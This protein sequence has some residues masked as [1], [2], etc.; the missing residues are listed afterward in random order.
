MVPNEGT[1][2]YRLISRD[3]AASWLY[4]HFGFDDVLPT[5]FVGYQQTADHLSHLAEEEWYRRNDTSDGLG[6]S[7]APKLDIPLNRA[8]CSMQPGDEALVCRLAYRVENPATKGQPQAE[9]WEYGILRC[10]PVEAGTYITGAKA[11]LS[12][13]GGHK[14]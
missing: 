5:S 2:S 1:F 6:L 11:A 8:K 3:Q 7:S 10:L 12:L 9:D 14:C 13:R 4:E